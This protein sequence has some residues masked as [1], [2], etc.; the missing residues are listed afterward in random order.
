[1]VTEPNT[2]NPLVLIPGFS[3]TGASWKPVTDDLPTR[4]LLA[5]IPGGLDFSATARALCLPQP[6]IYAGYS[7]GGR[8]ALQIAVDR[9]DRVTAL[10]L[11]STSPGIADPFERAQRR[12]EDNRLADWI[13]EVGR[14]AFLDHWLAQP[15]FA[16]LDEKAARIHRLESAGEIA[17][18]LRRL[19]P[20]THEPLWDRLESIHQPVVVIAGQR[21]E[22]YVAIATR[23]VEQIGSNARLRIVS[24]AGHAV[25][26]EQPSALAGLVSEIL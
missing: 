18:H 26:I 12:Q 3:L 13:D 14:E 16:G 23:I 7:M 17:D 11:I 21:D 5:E 20:G 4:P 22:R 1:L 19:G 6:A 24:N 2:T 25:P 10:A 9:P 15:L 8:L